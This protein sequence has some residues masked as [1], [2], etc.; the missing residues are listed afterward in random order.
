MTLTASYGPT[1]PCPNPAPPTAI[2]VTYANDG[3][4]TVNGETCTAV[5][6]DSRGIITRCPPGQPITQPAPGETTPDACELLLDCTGNIDLV[7]FHT[8]T[9]PPHTVSAVIQGCP[10]SGG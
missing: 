3:T 10:L 4:A 2:T 5:C 7:D 6:R 1:Q 8:D 9:T